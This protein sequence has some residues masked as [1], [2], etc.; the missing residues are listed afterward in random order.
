ML[1]ILGDNT[2][3]VNRC[4]AAVLFQGVHVKRKIVCQNYVLK[5][6]YI[7][8]FQLIVGR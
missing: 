7:E 3:N 6:L 5:K 8:G 2:V 4:V 1:D